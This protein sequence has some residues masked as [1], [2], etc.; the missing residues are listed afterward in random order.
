MIFSLLCDELSI[1]VCTFDNHIQCDLK[2]D[3]TLVFDSWIHCIFWNLKSNFGCCD[4][5]NA[6]LSGTL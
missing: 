2:K 6:L 1:I 5:I 3:W 4:I